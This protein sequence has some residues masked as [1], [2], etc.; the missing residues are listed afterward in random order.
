MRSVQTGRIP[1]CKQRPSRGR[2]KVWLTGL[3]LNEV[4]KNSHQNHSQNHVLPY[5]SSHLLYIPYTAL[6]TDCTDNTYIRD[7]IRII[8]RTARAHYMYFLRVTIRVQRL[9]ECR[10][11]SEE[12]TENLT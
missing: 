7:R 9:T 11:R 12:K 1:W 2:Y 10:R 8:L 4:S 6:Y 3:I 5:T